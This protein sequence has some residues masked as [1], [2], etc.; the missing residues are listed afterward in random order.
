MAQSKL[1]PATPG[2]SPQVALAMMS[3]VVL[4]LIGCGGDGLTG[5]RDVEIGG[6]TF[7]LELAMTGPARLQGLSDRES[8][9]DD[10]GMLFVFP[11]EAEREFVMR[12]CLVP[13]DILFLGPTGKV[14]AA[15]A[16]AVE[17]AGTPERELTRYGSRGK[18]AVAIELAG[19]TLER[20]GFGVGDTV[21][22]PIMELKRRAK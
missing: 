5:T 6:E 22:L 20:L 7:T 17:P 2:S 3:L 14:I 19:G 15:H 12:R 18:S 13:I 1:T 9:A 21:S 8:I 16:M 4:T 11:N 10:G